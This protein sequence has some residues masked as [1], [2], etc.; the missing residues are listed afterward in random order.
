MASLE[1]IRGGDG[2]KGIGRDENRE[3]AAFK[4]LSM[5]SDLRETRQR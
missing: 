3:A 1:F 2:K 5:S 4:F